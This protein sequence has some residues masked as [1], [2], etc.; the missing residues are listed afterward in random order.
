M[1]AVL[2]RSIALHGTFHNKTAYLISAG[3]AANWAEFDRRGVYV[4]SY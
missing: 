4:Y 1:K 3:Q 2:D